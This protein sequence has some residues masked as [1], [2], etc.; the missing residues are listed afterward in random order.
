MEFG[1]AKAWRKNTCAG[2]FRVNRQALAGFRD[3]WQI[4]TARAIDIMREAG[5]DHVGLIR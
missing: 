1:L 4:A 5:I 3:A 2:T